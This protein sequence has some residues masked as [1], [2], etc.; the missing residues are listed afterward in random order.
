M[1]LA[2]IN[3][4]IF[5][6]QPDKPY[7]EAVLIREGRFA[8]TGSTAEVRSA[9][10]P[11]AEMMDLAGRLVTPGLVDGHLH[12]LSF[13]RGL[14]QVDLR[15]LTSIAACREK[16]AAAV[17][18]ARPGEWIFGLG[19]NHHLWSDGRGPC[20][21]DLDDLTPDNPVLLYRMCCHSIWVNSQAMGLAGVDASTCNPAG[22]EIVK[23]AQGCPTG[24]I[25]E[26]DQVIERSVP[27]HTLED[28]MKWAEA[29]QEAAFR[30]GVTGVH[31]HE[32]MAEYQAL[33][34]LERG[35][36]LKIRVHHSLPPEELDT[37]FD[38]G[39][40]PGAGSDHLW[41]QQLKLFTD[42]SLGSGTALLH[43]E[44]SD[45]PGQCG[46]EFTAPEDLV[47]HVKAAYQK[48]LD[49]A[50]HAIGDKALTNALDAY[51]AARACHPGDHR[52]RVE[53][54]QLYREEDLARMKEMDM[55]AS[56]QPVHVMSDWSVAERRWG[57]HRAPR[58]YAYQSLLEAGL[59]VQFGS[60]A[61]VEA[62]NPVLGL[63]AAVTRQDMAGRPDGGWR[64]EQKFSL[65]QALTAFTSEPAYGARKESVMGTVE[66]GKW[67]DLTVLEQDLFELDPAKW[68][69]VQVELT[70]VNGEVVF[71]QGS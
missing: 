13:G 26:W 8:V 3:T 33:A 11:S 68:A 30:L 54:V 32:T 39:I 27:E 56:V 6:G 24:W 14:S 18:K 21:R 46:L 44:Y 42:G 48:G 7:V 58:A 23:D 36:R 61:P 29:A 60:D 66:P 12:F 38:Q 62:L 40:R 55:I 22:T 51:A 4:K 41:F 17:A 1:E 28:R 67:A 19:W 50:I 52:D 43:E 59:H 34:A 5:T 47:R 10:S 64:P 49:V 35:G 37:A 25:K 57:A 53:H 16:V 69:K 63:M 9:A 71:R 45:E 70:I 31:S 15:G 65:E 20:A 2:L